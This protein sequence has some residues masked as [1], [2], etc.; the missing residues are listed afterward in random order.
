[1]AV[2]HTGANV[3]NSHLTSESD[4]STIDLWCLGSDCVK[5]MYPKAGGEREIFHRKSSDKKKKRVIRN[6]S[7]V[8]LSGKYRKQYLS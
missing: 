8:E 7:K 3:N 5:T 4:L 1:M 6:H 2:T